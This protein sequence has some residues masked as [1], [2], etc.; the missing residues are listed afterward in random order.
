MRSI[1]LIAPSGASVDG[2]S[3]LAGIDWLEGQGILVHN[4]GCIQRVDERVAGSDEVRLA[5]LN[6]LP[7]L[8]TSTVVM[9]M[10]GGYGLHRLLPYIQ[11][12]AIAKA[13]QDGLQVCGHSDFTVF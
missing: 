13:I 4:A 3:P 2:K 9:V 6:N 10:R 8:D 5:E 7:N 1:Q 11:W 12:N